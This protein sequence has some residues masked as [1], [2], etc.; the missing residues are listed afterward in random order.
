[1]RALL[2][3]PAAALLSAQAPPPVVRAQ[4][5]WGYASPDGSGKGTLTVLV[6]PGTGRTLL[7]LMGLGERLAFLEG[8][9]KNGYHLIIPRQEVDQRALT[10]GGLAL[11]FLPKLGSPTA[12]H[13][14]LTEGEG[15]GVKVTRRDR[16]GPVK[17]T[18]AGKGDNGKELTVWLTRT[19]FQ[20]EPAPAAP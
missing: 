16:Q 13:R 20:T 10:L 1:M 11:P 6:D 7:E 8:D 9:A 15:P 12:L 17:L 3:L 19:R 18:Y 2:L 5:D 14:L 4:Y